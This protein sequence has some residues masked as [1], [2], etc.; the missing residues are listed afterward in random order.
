L[1]GGL[2]NRGWW[3]WD[4]LLDGRRGRRE[5]L[6]RWRERWDLLGTELTKV[7]LFE[8]APFISGSLLK[9]MKYR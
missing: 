9:I 6:D 5:L 8:S 1:S 7:G 4:L 2:L 3:R